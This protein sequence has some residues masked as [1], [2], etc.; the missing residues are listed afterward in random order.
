M[1]R[2]RVQGTDRMVMIQSTGQLIQQIVTT[3]SLAAGILF[4]SPWIL[5]G[6]G[7]LRDSGVH[8]RNAFRVHG[9]FAEFPADARETRNGLPADRWAAARKARK[10][11]SY[12]DWRP[13]LVDRYSK[14]SNE[15]HTAERGLAKRRAD[16]RNAA[17]RRL[18]TLG[19]YGSYAFV[20]YKT[21]IGLAGL[22]ARFT[23][24]AG[25]IAVASSNIQSVFTT[26]STIADQAMFI[27]DLLDFFT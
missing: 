7:G 12:S 23:F 26:F 9:L 3:I 13:F 14:L 25:A 10:S 1:E 5:S 6:P 16:H 17:S 18:G 15:L 22:S 27:T 20:I 21:V 4:F 2:A 11:S 8:G 19:Y 24:M